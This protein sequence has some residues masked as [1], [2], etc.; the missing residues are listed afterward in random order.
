MDRP[1]LYF[2]LL[3]YIIIRSE[4]IR[5]VLTEN[6]IYR[7]LIKNEKI[8]ISSRKIFITL[9][10]VTII[11]IAILIV[12]NKSSLKHI[13]A[14]TLSFKTTILNVKSI[15]NSLDDKKVGTQYSNACIESIGKLI[16]NSKQPGDGKPDILHVREQH[17]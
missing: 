13:V 4:N 12:P 14:D 8:I 5:K 10:I 2:Y 15:M 9:S 11:V 6:P 7:L 17:P 1:G 3:L 16:K